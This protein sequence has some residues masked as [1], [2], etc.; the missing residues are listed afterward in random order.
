MREHQIGETEFRIFE[1]LDDITIGMMTPFGYWYHEIDRDDWVDFL[2]EELTELKAL[3]V[4][5]VYFK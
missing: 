2:R 5:E 4:P 1:N 3:S